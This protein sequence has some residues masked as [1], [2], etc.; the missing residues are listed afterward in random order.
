MRSHF[1]STRLKQAALVLL[2]SLVMATLRVRAEAAGSTAP[3]VRQWSV[4][5]ITLTAERDFSNLYTDV[6]VT[7]RFIGPG[8]IK[9]AVNGFWDGGRAFK[10]RFT[11]PL[12]GRF[13]HGDEWGNHSIVRNWTGKYPVVNDEYGYI[14]E[15]Q[16]QRG[17]T[18]GRRLRHC[19]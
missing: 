16:D 6:Q 1:A 9:K 11:P 18:A 5:E 15:P 12:K 17:E 19:G 14:G 3:Q 8:G 2:P 7:A 4:H 13:R 10:V